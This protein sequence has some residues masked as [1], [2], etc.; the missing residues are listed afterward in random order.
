MSVLPVDLLVPVHGAAAELARLLLSLE[1]PPGALCRLVLALD[2]PQPEEVESLARG[3]PG[4][5]PEARVVRLPERAGFAAALRRAERESAGGD[6]VWLNSDVEV[7]AGWLGRLRAAAASRPRVASVTP[8]TNHGT[9]ASVPRWLEENT[10]PSGLDLEAFDALVE[11]VSARSY[12]E[13]PTGV[14][15]CMLVRREALEAAGG[16]DVEAFEL[17]YGEE[18]DWCLRAAAL[19]FRHLIDDATFVFHRGGASFG[20]E[21]RRRERRAQ[22]RLERRHRGWRRQL[23]TFLAADP[24]RP[25]REAILRELRPSRPAPAAARP[26]RIVHV[27]HGWPPWSQAGTEWYAARLARLQAERHEVAVLARYPGERRP[28][29]AALE[30]EDHGVRVRLLANDFRQ[31]D[32]LSRNALRERRFRRELGRLLDESGAQLVHFH[33]L[34]GFAL[35][36]PEAARARHLPRVVQLQ[37]WWFLC[38]RANRLDAGRQL[39]PGPRPGRCAR[40]LPMTRLIPGRLWSAA[41]YRLRRRLARRALAGAAAYIAGSRAVVDDLAAAGI[42]DPAVPV[43][44]LDYGVAAPGERA[45]RSEPAAGAALRLGFVGSLLPHKGLHVLLA[46]LRDLPATTAIHLDVWGGSGGG[47]PAYSQEIE[48][49]SRG[50]EVTFHPPFGEEERERLLGAL[51][52]LVAPSLGLESYGF[53]V[54]EALAA[55]TP[56][57]AAGRGA[58]VERLAAGGGGRFDPEDVPAFARQLRE[59]AT[60]PEVLTAWR[61]SIAPPPS[62]E[63]Q[64]EVVDA[65]YRQV[66]GGGEGR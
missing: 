64:V 31:R 48:A 51:D 20:A 58:L 16:L 8:L 34:A 43:H 15:F 62:F 14:G 63:D 6:L 65:I 37:D 29:A 27:V 50:L 11:R 18:V 53:A 52:L 47:D 35:D 44:V 26:L 54:V 41:L 32:P 39:C 7:P 60:Q 17:G 9:I 56:V 40:C 10:L 28:L 24:L 3:V 25:V 38:A 21:K 4:R 59:I 19:G 46:A 22:R 33:H 30:H 12:P 66:L 13:V 49:L 23:S 55:G 2:G 5:F 42:L 61:R 57:L 1:R 36:L 45:P